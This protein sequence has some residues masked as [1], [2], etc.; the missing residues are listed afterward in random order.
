MK[1]VILSLALVFCSLALVAQSTEVQAKATFLKA[2]EFYGNGN[3][4]DAVER[5]ESTKKLLGSS[6][7][8]IDHLL[9][10]SHW[11]LG[12]VQ[13][14]KQ[15]ISSYF[16]KAPDNDANY[17][18]ML[19]LLADAAIASEEQKA[20]AIANGKQQFYNLAQG[21]VYKITSSTKIVSSDFSGGQWEHT[22]TI[23]NGFNVKSARG[24]FTI[25]NTYESVL[26]EMH[27]FG[28]DYSGLS[29]VA[30]YWRVFQGKSYDFTMSSH[31]RIQVSPNVTGIDPRWLAANLNTYFPEFPKTITI[32]TTWEQT[33]YET[34]TKMQGMKAVN[35]LMPGQLVLK[36]EDMDNET[37]RVSM[38]YK[39]E[40]FLNFYFLQGEVTIDRAS[41]LPI[42]GQMVRKMG[43]ASSENITTF[44]RD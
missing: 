39:D 10:N 29:K 44:S 19:L 37:M 11:E 24:T 41:G 15:A 30:E 5:L 34:Q 21:Q 8:R 18:S 1:K 3:F 4:A 42:S 23:I 2:Q 33:I 25:S 22:M 40:P 32:G 17:N 36:V 13:E 20:K 28:V 43:S 27:P 35:T 12:N 16:D 9:A 38:K 7:P 26:F 14:A 31:G 6:N